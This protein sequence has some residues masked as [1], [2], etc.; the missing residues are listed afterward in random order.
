[1][2]E[3]CGFDE[4]VDILLQVTDECEEEIKE[5][6]DK[7]ENIAENK[8]RVENIVEKRKRVE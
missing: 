4:V 1:M 3:G 5:L 8:K 2:R 7:C 6:M